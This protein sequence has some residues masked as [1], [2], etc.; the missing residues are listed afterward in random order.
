MVL[1]P[2]KISQ[3]E[4]PLDSSIGAT[5]VQHRGISL[6]YRGKSWE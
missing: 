3:K 6:N 5:M 2:R 1:E 4:N